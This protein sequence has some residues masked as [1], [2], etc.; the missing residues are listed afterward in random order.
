MSR[1]NRTRSLSLLDRNQGKADIGAEL[2]GIG[3][4]EIV[5]EKEEEL[6][7]VQ[8]GSR[9][10]EGNNEKAPQNNGQVIE[11]PHMDSANTGLLPKAVETENPEAEKQKEETDVRQNTEKTDGRILQ[12]SGE[13][14][15]AAP[16]PIW[17]EQSP[18]QQEPHTRTTDG[19][20]RPEILESPL[21][22]SDPPERGEPP[23]GQ[24]Q[25][26]YRMQSEFRY[27]YPKLEQPEPGFKSF[28]HM[29]INVYSPKGGVGKSSISKEL[30]MAYTTAS[31]N[32]TPLKVLLVDADWEFGDITTLFNVSPRPNVTDWIRDMMTDKR[33]TG[34]IH[35]YSRQEIAAR[36]LIHYSDNLHILAGPGDPVE[37]ELVTEEM[38]TAIIESLKRTDYDIIVID[39][40]NSNRKRSLIPLMKADAVVLVETLDTSTVAE[41]TAVLN[42][43][44]TQQFDFGKLYMVL[45]QVPDDVSGMDISVSEISRLLQ[46]DIA[47]IIPRFEMLR[48]I[49]N[50]G[51]AA[52][53]K[54]S[55]PY[56]RAIYQ[57]ANR[58]VPLFKEEKRGVLSGLF[59]WLPRRK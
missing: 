18:P 3:T 41:T 22:R 59:R 6:S 48:V 46:L 33:Q 12:V 17:P 13:R 28:R 29:I 30:A 47:A 7:A 39:S 53:L 24:R 27:Q 2:F 42:T 57:L 34:H 14:K 16:Y 49:N 38:V 51:E 26:E 45:N 52:V 8:A 56:S 15:H 36:Y 1:E 43:L 54:K 40:A 10:T 9:E 11:N 35:L 50:A 23:A 5:E 44:R 21:C 58:I 32:H 19:P 37:A 25:P 4:P 31:I 20:P 55:T